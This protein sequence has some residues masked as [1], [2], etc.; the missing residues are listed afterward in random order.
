M[1]ASVPGLPWS[2]CMVGPVI[3]QTDY[4][5]LI[6]LLAD[7]ADVIAPDLRRSGCPTNISLIRRKCIQRQGR[8][9]VS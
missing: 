3:S 2:F 9:T 4:R 7:S 8:P 1:I 6:P 5:K